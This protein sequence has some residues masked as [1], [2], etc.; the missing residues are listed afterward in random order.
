M[1]TTYPTPPPP[2]PPQVYS[3]KLQEA[4]H[5][6]GFPEGSISVKSFYD[7]ISYMHINS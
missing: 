7:A 4:T 1:Y 3:N 5:V 6:V 2:P